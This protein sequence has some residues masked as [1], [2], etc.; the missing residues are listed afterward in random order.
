MIDFR[1][2]LVSIIAVF[3]ALAVG[4]VLGAGPLG[5]RVDENLPEQLN[6]VR[7]ENQGLRDQVRALEADQEFR[8][9]FVDVVSNELV[10]NRLSGRDIVVIAMPAADG[11]LVASTTN[12]LDRAGAT[13]TASVAIDPSWTESESEAA[14]DA[15]AAELVSSGTILPE[16]GNGYDRGAALLAGAL[17]RR[18]VEQSLADG[19]PTSVEDGAP[20]PN[21]ETD[22]EVLVALTEADFIQLEGEPERKASLAV[23]V[24]GFGVPADEEDSDEAATPIEPLLALAGALD[25][26]GSGA[27]VT[28]PAT[29][30]N[31]GGLIDTIREDEDLAQRLTTVDSINLPGGRVAVVF[32]L[33]EQEAGGVGQYGYL[34]AADGVLPPIPPR[35]FPPVDSQ[36]GGD[37]DET[38]GD[39]DG[40]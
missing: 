30:A 25:E 16:E 23:I 12:M 26:G 39:E 6:A 35:P 7:E 2:H 38:D 40:S 21:G 5:E 31:S 11:D 13:I 10:G 4:I 1:Y 9:G 37:T 24:D 29:T 20:A 28:G 36:N 33:I 19:L 34:G 3:F 8:D 22:D 27:V 18:P 32:A 17:L 15:L 14:L